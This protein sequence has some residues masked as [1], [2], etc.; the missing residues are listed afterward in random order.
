MMVYNLCHC[1]CMCVCV[2]TCVH[3]YV[4]ICVCMYE[5]VST[6]SSSVPVHSY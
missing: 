5:C 1:V 4:Y 3:V 2:R 6:W